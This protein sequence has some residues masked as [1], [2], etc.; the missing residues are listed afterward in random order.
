MN[1]GSLSNWDEAAAPP[2]PFSIRAESVI[3]AGT[4]RVR[5]F[6]LADAQLFPAGGKDCYC[7][8]D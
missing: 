1:G 7:D 2:T 6:E 3:L 4:V 8:Y 5:P